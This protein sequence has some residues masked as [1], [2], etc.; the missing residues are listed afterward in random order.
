MK[1]P[2]Q[3]RQWVREREE[4]ALDER[5]KEEAK[6]MAKE[7]EFQRWLYII[8]TSPSEKEV[9]AAI[10]MAEH[11]FI[12]GSIDRHHVDCLKGFAAQQ[13]GKIANGDVRQ[14]SSFFARFDRM[15]PAEQFLCVAGSIAVFTFAA[16]F[17]LGVFLS[18]TS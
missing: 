17:A 10:S 8:T 7:G 14:R 18:V 12:H 9:D 16:M 11:K 1:T 15:Q 13:K 3:L 4:V 5:R 2:Q 6:A